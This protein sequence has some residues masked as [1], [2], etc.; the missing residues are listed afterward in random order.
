MFT[1][2]NTVLPKSRDS[3]VAN[4][5]AAHVLRPK[6]AADHITDDLDEQEQRKKVVSKAL[7]HQE[8]ESLTAIQQKWE[9]K[10]ARWST[11]APTGSSAPKGQRAFVAMSSS[12]AMR[13]GEQV[14][15]PLSTC[16]ADK[17]QFPMS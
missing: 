6:Y 17:I 3:D 14:A 16:V 13:S 1:L 5:T 10:F 2:P 9:A 11:S 4:G 12:P 15:D 7:F 8:A